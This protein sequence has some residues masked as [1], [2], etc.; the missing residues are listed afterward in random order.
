MVAPSTSK[1]LG[2]ILSALA[3][4]LVGFGIDGWLA[5]ATWIAGIVAIAAGYRQPRVR[6][7][8]EKDDI[9]ALASLL[10]LATFLRAYRIAEV[11]FGL[12]I[13]EASTA[14][15]ARVLVESRPFSPFGMTPLLPPAPQWVQTSNLYL[16]LCWLLEWMSGFTLAGVKLISVVPGILAI[17]AL[18]I[19]ARS[20]TDR[21]FAFLAAGLL[22]ASTWH[23]TLSRW[24]WDEVLATTLC[25]LTFH[26]LYRATREDCLGSSLYAG[27]VAGLAL[28]TYLGA[29]VGLLAALCF[30][31]SQ[32]AMTRNRRTLDSV[33]AFLAGA[34]VASSP[35]LIRWW[36]E[37]QSFW[38][39]IHGLSSQILH[40][41]DTLS[42]MLGNLKNHLLMFHWAGDLNP[43][44]SLSG[45]PMLDGP[46]GLLM[47]VGLTVALRRLRKAEARLALLWLGV[48]LLGGILST[49]P[50]EGPQTYRTGLVAPVCCLLAAM[51]AGAIWVWLQTRLSLSRHWRTAAVC[52]LVAISGGITFVNYFQQR[53]A[54]PRAWRAHGQGAPA[55]I[56]RQ[57]VVA[58]VAQGHRVYLDPRLRTLPLEVELGFSSQPSVSELIFARNRSGADPGGPGEGEIAG[59]V[60]WLE[61]QE[62]WQQIAQVLDSDDDDLLFVHAELLPI[63]RRH[64]SQDLITPLHTPF[65]DTLALCLGSHCRGE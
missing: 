28:Y 55:K 27:L 14:Y 7:H 17:P 48:G 43:R 5:F 21:A 31:A 20:C 44:H 3:A 34:G 61:L 25:V 2:F 64:L 23:V 65:G 52:A 18:Y 22:A 8:L 46:T 41:S 45:A 10:L 1:I 15:N 38:V 29:R 11:P 49:L 57:H 51:G 58:A 62:R 60:E 4:T 19:L 35:L 36:M 56:L 42:V 13:D 26:F 9:L 53:P 37:P 50:G 12:W 40:E 33:A 54:D 24:G 30:L 32:L 63:L 59:R 47:V 39:R 16:Y 6:S